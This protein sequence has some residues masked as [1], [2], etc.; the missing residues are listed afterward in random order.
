MSLTGFQRMRRI[1]ADGKTPLR[2]DDSEE[3]IKAKGGVDSLHGDTDSKELDRH[4]LL[5]DEKPSRKKADS[6]HG[7]EPYEKPLEEVD[8]L[9]ADEDL[10][11]K[12]P[13]DSIHGEGVTPDTG[14]ISSPGPGG[15]EVPVVKEGEPAP[16]IEHFKAKEAAA[17][18]VRA[19]AESETEPE[20][21]APKKR[22]PGRPPKSG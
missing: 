11:K 10:S 1:V 21:E 4:P 12:V 17:E 19:G 6:L 5:A 7:E 3:E 16:G 2:A 22:G 8:L 18:E 20:P 15:E 9:P 13:F 14:E